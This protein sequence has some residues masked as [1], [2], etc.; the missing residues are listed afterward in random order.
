MVCLEK[1]KATL[2]A[3]VKLESVP[4]KRKGKNET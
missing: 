2:E 4:E 3:E 1:R